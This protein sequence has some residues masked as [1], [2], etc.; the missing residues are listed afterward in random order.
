MTLRSAYLISIMKGVDA[1][2]DAMDL[3]AKKAS[4]DSLPVWIKDWL[5]N[6]S[7]FI[8][9][10]LANGAAPFTEPASILPFPKIPLSI[11][12]KAAASGAALVVLAPLVADLATVL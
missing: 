7:S 11:V 4:T 8:D 12:T 6:P 1:L 10:D 9:L 2:W 5:K 3:V